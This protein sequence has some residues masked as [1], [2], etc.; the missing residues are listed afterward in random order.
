MVYFLYNFLVNYTVLVM[1][2]ILDMIVY[3]QQVNYYYHNIM[4]DMDQK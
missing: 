3:I 1:D 4:L 2:K